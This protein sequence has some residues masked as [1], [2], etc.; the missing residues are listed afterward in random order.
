MQN[1]KALMK[2][3]RSPKPESA[4]NSLKIRMNRVFVMIG[5]EFTVQTRCASGKIVLVRHTDCL[6][7][8]LKWR[9]EI[10]ITDEKSD[11]ATFIHNHI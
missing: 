8:A 11:F 2:K 7:E 9:R 5:Q 3:T 4:I 1:R 10:D 6:K